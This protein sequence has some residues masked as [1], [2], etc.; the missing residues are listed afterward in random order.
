M[1]LGPFKASKEIIDG[2]QQI[3]ERF[4]VPTGATDIKVQLANE[5]SIE[6]VFFDDIRIHPF[7]A[8]MK[9]FVY[10]PSSLRLWAELDERNYATYYEYD[11]EGAL[12]RIEKETHKG[13]KTIQESASNTHK[14]D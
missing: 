8:S 12:I 4:E 3:E 1:T 6:K 11:E 5:G 7:K 9:S 14:A 13:R 10:D 2:W